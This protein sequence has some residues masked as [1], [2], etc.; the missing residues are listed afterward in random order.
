MKKPITIFTILFVAVSASAQLDYFHNKSVI[1]DSFYQQTSP[2][3][4]KHL[5]DDFIYGF[6]KNEDFYVL[7]YDLEP[8]NEWI[9]QEKARVNGWNSDRTVNVSYFNKD[10]KGWYKQEKTIMW[11]DKETYYEMGVKFTEKRD[12]VLY[13]STDGKNWAKASNPVQTDYRISGWMFTFTEKDTTNENF[14]YYS[15]VIK[16]GLGSGKLRVLNNGCV[17]MLLHNEYNGHLKYRNAVAILTPNGDK[18]YTATR[19]EPLSE[20]KRS[21]DLQAGDTLIIHE[22]GND[23]VMEFWER[24]RCNEN[25]NPDGFFNYDSD[26]GGK[27]YKI[28]YRRELANTLT[29]TL[30]NGKVY[31]SGDY[32]LTQAQ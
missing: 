23:M 22:K 5:T 1:T 2:G 16:K 8:E 9:K 10:V 18:S 30:N 20:G 27:V 11:T 19:F 28:F 6:K 25:E 26:T 32:K 12:L 3:G 31:Y 14:D 15:R 29:F 13:R 17:V 21:P 24:Y 7:A 4:F